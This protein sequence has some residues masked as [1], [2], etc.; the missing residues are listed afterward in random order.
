[1]PKLSKRRLLLEAFHVLGYPEVQLRTRRYIGFMTPDSKVLLVGKSG[2]L[3]VKAPEA[4][5]DSSVSITGWKYYKAL[6]IVGE[7]AADDFY[8]TQDQ[9]R[10]DLDFEWSKM[11]PVRKSEA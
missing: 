4:R 6:L 8:T 3:R 11:R 9:A 5:I 7:R 10:A 1:M 2:A